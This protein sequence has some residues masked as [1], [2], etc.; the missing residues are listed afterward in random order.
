MKSSKGAYNWYRKIRQFWPAVFFQAVN[1]S[2]S[3][4]VIA[5]KNVYV[6]KE[7]YKCVRTSPRYHVCFFLQILAFK[8]EDVCVFLH[9]PFAAEKKKMIGKKNEIGHRTSWC[10]I[11][12]VQHKFFSFFSYRIIPHKSFWR[13]HEHR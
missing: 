10:H 9:R 6:I 7:S 5:T 12:N 13:A 3:F 11:W 2:F 4:C 8:V 1:L